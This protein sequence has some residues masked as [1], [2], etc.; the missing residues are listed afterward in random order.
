MTST[1]NTKTP[2][3]A[4][5]DRVRDVTVIGAGPVGLSAAF[6]CGMRSASV[7]IID[8]LAAIGGQCAALYPEKL[9]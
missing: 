9:V 3:V 1:Y 5:L 7:R 2:L 8:S 6:W 4:D